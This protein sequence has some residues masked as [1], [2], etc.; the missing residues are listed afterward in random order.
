MSP[1]LQ[2]LCFCTS[3]AYAPVP[4]TARSFGDVWYTHEVLA[5]GRHLLRLSSTDLLLDSDRARAHRLHAFAG[6]FAARTC[7]G[8]FRLVD[9]DRLSAYAGQVV[10]VCR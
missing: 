6:D 4:Q 1:L 3:I 8:R 9:T 10:F 5:G 7:G 2:L